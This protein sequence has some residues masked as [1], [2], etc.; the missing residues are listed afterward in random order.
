VKVFILISFSKPT[1][2]VYPLYLSKKNQTIRKK[3]QV[4]GT[5]RKRDWETGRPGDGEKD[6]FDVQSNATK[7]CVTGVLDR[8][9]VVIRTL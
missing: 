4:S 7:H 3:I 9:R 8:N 2:C 6:L 5:G 1:Y